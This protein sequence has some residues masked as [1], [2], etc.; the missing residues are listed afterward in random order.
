ML[1]RT[2]FDTP[3]TIELEHSHEQL[4]AHVV[5]ADGVGIGPGDQVHVHGAPIALGFGERRVVERMATVVRAS[6]LE[7]LWTKLAGHFELAE[8]WEVSFSNG[9]LP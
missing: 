1:R 6:A 2:R 9:K 7:R 4:C 3:C 8:L 5:L